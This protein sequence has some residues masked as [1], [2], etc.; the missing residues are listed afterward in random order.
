VP[1]ITFVNKLEN[2]EGNLKVDRQTADGYHVVEA[3]LPALITV[4]AGVNEPRYASFKGIMAAKKKPVEELSLGDL[5]LSGDDVATKQTVKE[6]IPAAERKAGEVFED[7]G[8]GA[9]KIADFLAEA[10]V[11]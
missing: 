10:K 2:S 11:I 7:D 6:L 8:T 4:T 9:Q 3:P 5:G 1:M